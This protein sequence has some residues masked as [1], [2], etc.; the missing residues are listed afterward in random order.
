VRR[1]TL[2]DGPAQRALQASTLT[3]AEVQSVFWP[4]HDEQNRLRHSLSDVGMRTGSAKPA[5]SVD[6][7]LPKV[8]GR[9]N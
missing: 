5:S 1:T 8:R 4:P 2:A 6:V 3:S 9:K 7:V